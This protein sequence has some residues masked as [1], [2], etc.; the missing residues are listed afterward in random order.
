MSRAL[1]AYV[2]I[3]ILSILNLFKY[4]PTPRLFTQKTYSHEELLVRSSRLHDLCA[5]HSHSA[6]P[7]PLLWHGS[8]KTAALR[9]PP[10]IR[11]IRIEDRLTLSGIVHTLYF[12]DYIIS[13]H[14]H[15]SLYRQF[16]RS[17]EPEHSSQNE[18]HRG[19]R[20]PQEQA[21]LQ[22]VGK[23]SCGFERFEL[24]PTL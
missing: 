24:K 9:T 18:A 3:N 22:P 6:R 5:P 14:C 17:R 23:P 4:V 7:A 2:T 15:H 20:E 8:P 13:G 21:C 1:P 16:C 12:V 10:G 19:P 11:H